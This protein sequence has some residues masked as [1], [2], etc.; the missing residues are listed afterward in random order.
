MRKLGLRELK[1]L[2]PECQTAS[3]SF[4]GAAGGTVMGEVG[5]DVST[6]AAPRSWAGRRKRRGKHL[7]GGLGLGGPVERQLQSQTEAGSGPCSA[8]LLAQ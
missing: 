4:E 5:L 7:A 8:V 3:R 2:G 1:H 6:G